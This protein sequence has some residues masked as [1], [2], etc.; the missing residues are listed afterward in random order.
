[1]DQLETLTNEEIKAL[2]ELRAVQSLPNTTT[3]TSS[4]LNSAQISPSTPQLKQMEQN[5]ELFEPIAKR[6]R[7]QRVNQCHNMN[8]LRALGPSGVQV[9]PNLFNYLFP[10]VPFPSSSMSSPSSDLSPPLERIQHTPKR[11]KK[12]KKKKKKK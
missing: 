2:S 9:G 6:T 3:S 7:Q 10:D 12:H 11:R 8:D 1:M 4:T 5:P